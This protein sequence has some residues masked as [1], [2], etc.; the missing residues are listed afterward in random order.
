MADQVNII[1]LLASAVPSAILN[2]AISSIITSNGGII[3]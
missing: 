1:N 3:N 2:T